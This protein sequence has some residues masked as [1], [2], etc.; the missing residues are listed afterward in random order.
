M[1]PKFLSSRATKIVEFYFTDF[2]S[3]V[4]LN[5]KLHKYVI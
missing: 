4:K 2:G 5:S 1:H 3:L